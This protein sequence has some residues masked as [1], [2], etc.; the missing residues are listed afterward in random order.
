MHLKLCTHKVFRD[1]CVADVL[2]TTSPDVL[3][4]GARAVTAEQE[5]SHNICRWSYWMDDWCIMFK[6]ICI[7]S[8][9]AVQL[10]EMSKYADA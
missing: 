1:V 7:C 5:G 4:Q 6:Y 2:W 9:N 3:C 10:E 8:A